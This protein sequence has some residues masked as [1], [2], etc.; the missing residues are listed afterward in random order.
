MVATV[1]DRLASA[2]GLAPQDRKHDDDVPSISNADLF[3]EH[4][5]TVRDFFVELAPSAQAVA[6]YVYN[7]FP[8]VHWIGKYN[9]TWFVGDF[10]AGMMPSPRVPL[11]RGPVQLTRAVACKA[12]PSAPSSSLRA[13]RMPSSPSC[14]SSTACTLPLWAF[15]STG[16]LPHPRT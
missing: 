16:S 8:F 15:S 14:P 6:R 9:S 11:A 7:L 3:V 4:E 12:P 1:K 5:P 13:W 2:I 10:I